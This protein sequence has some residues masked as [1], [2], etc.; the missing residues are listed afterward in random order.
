MEKK[1]LDVVLEEQG[2]AHSRSKAQRMVMAGS[3]RVNDQVALK[4][5]V[6]VSESDRIEVTQPPRFV[7]RGGEKLLA[8]VVAF[9]FTD[10]TGCICVDVGASTGGFTDC[11]LQHGAAKVYAVDVGY[12]VLD[13]KMR[14]DPRVV[15]M[16]KTNAR[17]V[18]SFPDSIDLVVVD[19]SFI[20]LRTLLPV[21]RTWFGSGEGTVIALIK[22]QFEAGRAE[23]ARGSGVIRDTAVHRAVLETILTFAQS[24]GFDVIGLIRSPLTGPK[25]NAEFLVHLKLP[26]KNEADILALVQAVIPDPQDPGNSD[27]PA[28][29]N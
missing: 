19:A 27:Q 9:G 8:A 15:V 10:L 7:S 5:S 17:Y 1:R 25:G 14:N 12:G 2:F 24:E 22:P 3:V 23:T 11:L 13:W 16:E 20:S 4:P 18:N 6:K 26:K 28:A 29:S 21:I